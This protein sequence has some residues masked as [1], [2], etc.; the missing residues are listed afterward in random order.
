MIDCVVVAL[1]I[2]LDAPRQKRPARRPPVDVRIIVTPAIAE[3]GIA[4]RSSPPGLTFLSSPIIPARRLVLSSGAV[5]FDLIV[6]IHRKVSS[7]LRLYR[8]CL[9]RVRNRRHEL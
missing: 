3:V 2:I 1:E 7:V 6:A 8:I 4:I 5:H 9:D